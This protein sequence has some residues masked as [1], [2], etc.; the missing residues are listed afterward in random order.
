MMSSQLKD[1][2]LEAMVKSIQQGDKQLQ[3]YLLSTYQPFIAKSVSEVCKRYI[4]PK[5]DDEFSIGLS[6]FNEAIFSYSSE[7][8]SSFLSFAK[9]VV[10]RKVIDYIRYN[11][12]R[13]LPLSLDETYDAEQMENPLEIVAVKEKYSQEIDTIH[14]K[15][16]I[17]DFKDKLKEYK[18]TL[19]DLTET[20]PKHK[21]ARDSAVRTA[22]ILY[23][24]KE[25]REFVHAK[26]KLPIKELV[27][28]VDV[29]KKTLE[30]NRKFILAIFIVLSED[31]IYLKDYLKG[32]GQ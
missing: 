3:N 2:P 27:K 8:G 32:V 21:D 25:L 22:R 19:I 16:E 30:R 6:A 18:L 23:R 24:D 10:K 4:D 13:P 29:S 12:K 7:K 28:K 20:S 17:M 5:K 1:K 15:E 14:R 26:K 11:K 31:Y 9:L